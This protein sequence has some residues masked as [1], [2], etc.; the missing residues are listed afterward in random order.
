VFGNHCGRFVLKICSA[1]GGRLERCPLDER[2]RVKVCCG[3][4]EAGV[5]IQPSLR[6]VPARR[7]Y[8]LGTGIN[9][10]AKTSTGS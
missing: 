6:S 5:H 2:R 10:R 8:S 9:L 3:C 7:S 4:N 1:Q